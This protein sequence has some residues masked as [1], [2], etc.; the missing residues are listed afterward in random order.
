MDGKKTFGGATTRKCPKC[1]TALQT[2]LRDGVDVDTCSGCKGVWVDRIEQK[3]LLKI[4]PEAFTMDDLENFRTLYQSSVTLETVRYYPCAV[5]GE[6]MNR[7]N[8]ASFSNVV[9]DRCRDHGDWY[10][11]GELEKVREFVSL[12]GTE[13]EKLRIS[14]K[15]LSDLSSKLTREVTRLDEKVDRAYRK[16]RLYSMLGM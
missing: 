11:A 7:V 12:G 3:D 14:E 6:M 5:C 10:D 13:F 16:A 4:K 8:Y 1:T 15:G 2:A 9:V